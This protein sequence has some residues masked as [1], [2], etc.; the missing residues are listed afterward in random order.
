MDQS[1]S[2][3][4]GEILDSRYILGIEPTRS[5]ENPKVI[6]DEKRPRRILF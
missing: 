2:N 1:S 6:Q 3:G 5:L 4:G